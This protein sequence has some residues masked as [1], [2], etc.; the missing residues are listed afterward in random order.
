MDEKRVMDITYDGHMITVSYIS[1]I[2]NVFENWFR[3]SE[4]RFLP[5]ILYFLI[6][7]YISNY[8]SH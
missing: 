5:Y 7:M 3:V 2:I 1:E 8:I 4:P 6:F